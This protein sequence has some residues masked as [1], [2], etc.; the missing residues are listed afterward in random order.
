MKRP[1]P[2]HPSTI[3]GGDKIY[4]RNVGDF[5]GD[6]RDELLVTQPFYDTTNPQDADIAKLIFPNGNRNE[7]YAGNSSDVVDLFIPLSIT[8]STGIFG[9]VAAAGDFD[10]N[11]ER[12]LA[13]G[14]GS[15]TSLT[16]NL[17][18]DGALIIYRNGNFTNFDVAADYYESGSIVGGVVSEF[19]STLK[20]GDF[21]G[22]G[23]DDLAVG[24]PEVHGGTAVILH[25]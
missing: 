5:N 19:V 3:L 25:D 2:T 20:S 17:A 13:V 24:M 15:H 4:V 14:V 18:V 7:V 23:R 1:F 21:N 16:S 9:H 22:D 8:A 10:G 6:G 11:G 12:D